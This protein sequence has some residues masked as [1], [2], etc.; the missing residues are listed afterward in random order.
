MPAIATN[1]AKS[2]LASNI[3]NTVVTTVNLA[4]G[5]G[6][7]FPSPSAGEYFYA[8]IIKS[9]N[10]SEIVKCTSRSGDALTVVR[11]QDGSTASTF[12]TGDRVELRV[13]AAYLNE[14]NAPSGISTGKAI[15][16][17]MVFG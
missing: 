12:S 4:T 7:L 16:M 14:A 2:T 15:A 1:N 3:S 8:T 9:D 17:A 6:A 13:V 5:G 11:A 10:T